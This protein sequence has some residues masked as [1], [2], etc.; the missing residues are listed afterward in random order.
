M[1]NTEQKYNG[2]TNHETWCVNLHITNE[3]GSESYWRE[4]AEAHSRQAMANNSDTMF[5]WQE[6]AQFSL[7][8]ALKDEITDGIYECLEAAEKDGNEFYLSLIRDLLSDDINWDEIAK[9]MIST[10]EGDNDISAIFDEI[11]GDTTE[12]EEEE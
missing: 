6:R 1:T 3:Q 10:F 12:D 9:S 2:W 5:T 11:N 8:D 7:A 4:E